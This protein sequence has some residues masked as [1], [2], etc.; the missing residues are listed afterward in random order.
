MHRFPFAVVLCLVLLAAREGR[1]DFTPVINGNPSEWP[2]DPTTGFMFEDSADL[3]WLLAHRDIV[4]VWATNDN[5]SGSNGNLYLLIETAGDFVNNYWGIDIDFTLRLDTN[6]DGVADRTMELTEGARAAG[7]QF[8]SSGRFLEVAIPYSALGLTHGADTIGLSV[9]TTGWIQTTDSGPD[10]GAG[11][12]GF[13]T[14]DGT[15][16]DGPIEPLAVRMLEQWAQTADGGVRVNWTTGAEWRNAG[17]HVFRRSAQ[18]WTRLTDVPV[19]GLG[20]SAFGRSYT[21]FDAQGDTDSFYIIADVDYEGA[22]RTHGIVTVGDPFDEDGMSVWTGTGAVDLWEQKD[23]LSPAE[24]AEALYWAGAGLEYQINGPATWRF[25]VED[26]G[27]HVLSTAELIAAGVSSPFVTNRLLRNLGRAVPVRVSSAGWH[28]Y[29]DPGVNR[30]ADALVLDLGPGRRVNMARRQAVPRNCPLPVVTQY[31]QQETFEQNAVYSVSSP[32][33][34]PFFWNAAYVGYPST[35]ELPPLDGATDVELEA[36]LVGYAA[37]PGI[38]HTVALSLNG[39]APQ[40]FEWC[41][42]DRFSARMPVD[43]ADLR[44]EGNVLEVRIATEDVA[45][46][47]WLDRV[48]VHARRPLALSDGGLTFPLPK[49]K[50][51]LVSGIPRG[52]S[53]MVLDI[54]NPD[55][56]V[57]LTGALRLRGPAGDS[58]LFSQNGAPNAPAGTDRVYHLTTTADAL[59]P[60]PTGP[61]PFVSPLRRT[62]NEADWLVITHPAFMEA[63]QRIADHRASSGWRTMV[64]TTDEVYDAFRSGNRHPQAIRDFLRATR[65]WNAPPHSVLLLGAAT[66]DPL[67]WLGLGTEDYVPAPF[68]STLAQHYEAASDGWYV[69]GL[70]GVTIGR[71]PVETPAQALSVVDK[72]IAWDGGTTG[73]SLYVADRDPEGQ[74]IP[75]AERQ[76]ELAGQS[77]G[78]AIRLYRDES[79]SAPTDLLAEINEGIDLM[80]FNGHA[81]L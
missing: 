22:T 28:F 14:Y 69:E 34:D 79:T 68:H 46:V 20:D 15:V 11:E 12:N 63:A 25:E 24:Q 41:G 6:G 10:A 3:L 47:I 2:M 50:C 81:Y 73:R 31:L 61:I 35:V 39:G 62:D 18:Q 57:E 44:P 72:I 70:P 75:A 38:D 56:P 80:T 19:P 45:D 9:T 42:V 48:T 30:Y 64:V 54:T 51:A 32:S 21:F 74:F 49:G 53:V 26:A 52:Q 77:G 7:G 36:V 33:A 67:G 13:I 71:L 43:P 40:V 16:G 59:E 8:A 17:F 60:I 5:T 23:S 58:L 1:S 66:V 4:Q 65:R 27:L 37:V 29:A 78:E 55:R 76:I